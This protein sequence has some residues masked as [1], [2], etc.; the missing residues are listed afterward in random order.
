MAKKILLK[1][2]SVFL[3]FLMVMNA[4]FGLF[5]SMKASAENSISLVAANG[6]YSK[7]Q[8]S[9]SVNSVPYGYEGVSNGV[10]THHDLEQCEI[11]DILPEYQIVNE[12][13]PTMKVSEGVD[14]SS[15]DTS[16]AVLDFWI[17]IKDSDLLNKLS[18]LRVELRN[19]RNGAG[20]DWI[21]ESKLLRWGFDNTT[22][23]ELGRGWNHISLAF[24][25][26]V[27]IDFD[28]SDVRSFLIKLN[29]EGLSAFTNS[30][31]VYDIKIEQNVNQTEAMKILEKQSANRQENILIS[32]DGEYA[33]TTWS[34]ETDFTPVGYEGNSFGVYTHSDNEQCE[35]IDILPLYKDN[36]DPT[37]DVKLSEGADLS[38]VNP[39]VSVLDFWIYIKDISVFND[40]TSFQIS[41]RNTRVAAGWDETSQLL[42]WDLGSENIEKLI[43]GWNHISITLS[44]A[45]NISFDYSDI[46]AFLIKLQGENLLSFSDNINIFNVKIIENVY[47]STSFEVVGRQYQSS[48]E[49]ILAASDGSY[50]QCEWSTEDSFTP[51][52]EKG[53]S[54]GV[55]THHDLEQCEIIN[56]LPEYE[57]DVIYDS[58]CKLSGGVDISELDPVAS[59]LDFW[60]CINDIS[61][62]E[63][64]GSL[65]F[66]LRNTR[67][68]DGGNWNETSQ[69]LSWTFS[70]EDVNKLKSG[71]NHISLSFRHAENKEF[72]YSDV[73]AFMVKLRGEN[74]TS[75]AD[76]LRIYNIKAVS[77]Y[78]QETAVEFIPQKPV[79]STISINA[80]KYEI[81][82]GE[83]LQF[84]YEIEEGSVAD[85]IWSVSP[86]SY[87]TINGDGMLTAKKG[88]E[89]TV[90]ATVAGT[91]V[92]A[93]K[94]VKITS[95]D[96]TNISVNKSEV[97]LKVGESEQITIE[98]TPDNATDKSV[99]WTVADN[100]IASVSRGKITAL[101]A[102]TTVVTVSSAENPDVKKEITVIVTSDEE[103]NNSSGENNVDES[104]ENNKTGL[105]I[106]ICAGAAAVIA[107]CVIVIVVKIKGK[108]K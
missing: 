26:A 98:I 62:L 80:D 12:V 88:G 108:N 101:K 70:K 2:S 74:L 45:E 15:V 106:G 61:V 78:S 81:K 63:T 23:S 6:E 100:T 84:T 83:T 104:S 87:A 96:V 31:Y 76:N 66:S 8:W 9:A 46:R 20:G 97:N 71:W 44:S 77:Q 89:V 14:I 69:L 49:K 36:S 47:Q 72:D 10:Y 57:D 43:N 39:A 22:V 1:F 13:N 92:K 105:V 53:V 41:L 82:A 56:L 25:S 3:L 107:A 55:Y 93:E 51:V 73:R 7:A 59:V 48:T 34:E 42:N 50:A 65:E 33:Q 52:G 30:V 29:G 85:V 79:S 40:V 86:S 32:S 67:S 24:N 17:Y 37:E 19:T 38:L 94:T 95:I 102:G 58:T 11:I 54:F 4:S 68:G 103:Q 35:V 99:T 27:D 60:F 18:Q 91:A 28:Y 16:K 75:Y 21:E 5:F 64:A 90:S